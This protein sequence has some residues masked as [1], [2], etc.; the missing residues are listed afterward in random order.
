[1][2][3]E[4][5]NDLEAMFVGDVVPSDDGSFKCPVCEKSYKR[6][7]NA[8][9]HFAEKLC[10]S[11]RNM[12]KGTETEGHLYTIYKQLRTTQYGTSSFFKFQKS[13]Q[14]D[15]IARFHIF[16]Y[17]NNVREQFSYIQYGLDRFSDDVK[18]AFQILP[19]LTKESILKDYYYWRRCNVSV[20]ES[21][22]FVNSNRDRLLEDKNFMLRSLERGDVG[23]QYLIDN[24]GTPAIIEGLSYVQEERLENFLGCHV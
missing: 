5:V 15:I 6:K 18:S 19:I 3:V 12:F 7:A 21:D 1:M 24:F 17:D 9:K 4:I 22:M 2:T 23:L 20:D 14:Y 10:Y 13:K 16:C 11:Y 8:E